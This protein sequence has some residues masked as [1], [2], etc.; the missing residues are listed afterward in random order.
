[1]SDYRNPDYV[2]V[3]MPKELDPRDHCEWWAGYPVEGEARW[4]DGTTT[5][6]KITT[7]SDIVGDT[8]IIFSWKER[9]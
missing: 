3:R 7:T 4:A 9:Q 1:M 2:C 8:T 5:R 6:A